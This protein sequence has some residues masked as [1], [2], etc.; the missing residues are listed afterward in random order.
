MHKLIIVILFL[1]ASGAKAQDQNDP[2]EFFNSSSHTAEAISYLNR[3]N[4]KPGADTANKIMS[5]V[6]SL[7]RGGYLDSLAFFVIYA[8]NNQ[9]NGLLDIKNLISPSAVNSPTFTRYQGI[10]GDGATSYVNLNFNDSTGSALFGRTNMTIGIYSISD[11]NGSTPALGVTNGGTKSTSIYPRDGGKAY[12][13]CREG[14]GLNVTVSDSKGMYAMTLTGTTLKGYKNIGFASEVTVSGTI[15]PTGR[16]DLSYFTSARNS[17]GSPISLG[18][19][20]NSCVWGGAYISDYGVK[21]ITLWFENLMDY[22][23]TG[24]I[25]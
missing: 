24:V 23:G 9:A 25:P 18:M 11:I 14:T 16:A 7:K 3:F 4:P 15:A 1:F 20:I 6:D 10:N 21:K 19:R 2:F 17:S 22:F 5:F 8:M 12:F 13:N